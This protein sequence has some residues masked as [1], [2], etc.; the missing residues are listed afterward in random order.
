MPVLVVHHVL[1]GAGLAAE[2]H[3]VGA[4]HALHPFGQP[5]VGEPEQHDHGQ[6][7]EDQVE[8][9]IPDGGILVDRAELHPRRFS[10]RFTRSPSWA[11]ALGLVGLV[12]GCPTK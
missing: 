10:S 4:A 7:A 8:Q 2:Q 5:A 3:G 12:P 6:H 9:G 11:M 1:L